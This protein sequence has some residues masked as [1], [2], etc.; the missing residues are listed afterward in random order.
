M[1]S[2]SNGDYLPPGKY[3]RASGG[4][5]VYWP[6]ILVEEGILGSPSAPPGQLDWGSFGNSV[7]ICPSYE[8][9]EGIPPKGTEPSHNRTGWASLKPSDP[10][11]PGAAE[12]I[13]CWYGANGAGDTDA[14]PFTALASDGSG[15]LHSI[16]RL[17]DM[18]NCVGIFDGWSLHDR[19]PSRIAV[20]HRDETRG[21]VS[22]LD[23]HA[24]PIES[25]R[26]PQGRIGEGTPKT[27]HSLWKPRTPG[28]TSASGVD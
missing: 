22:F 16:S 25:E 24:E 5:D 28:D 18:P 4:R 15:T 6:G 2:E 20:R 19:I 3:A 7:F 13:P 12:V 17:G 14:F 9:R 23:G 8:G 10:N 26:L 21:T 11:E 27:Y 1:Y